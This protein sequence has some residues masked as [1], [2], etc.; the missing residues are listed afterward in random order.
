M[1]IVFIPEWH[2]AIFDNTIFMP[3]YL[4]GCPIL[5]QGNGGYFRVHPFGDPRLLP[6]I[7]GSAGIKEATAPQPDESPIKPIGMH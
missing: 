3:S 1:P 4:F 2:H 6:L 5:N 7:G